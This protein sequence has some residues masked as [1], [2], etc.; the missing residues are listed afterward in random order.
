M[1]EDKKP[2]I[3]CTVCAH[4]KLKE[5][6][7]ALVAPNPNFSAIA[8]IFDLKRDNVRRHLEKGHVAEKITKAA[9]A[10]EALDADDLLKEFQQIQ[11]HQITIFKEAR[12]RKAKGED[13]K[14]K[15]YPDNKL[16]LEALRDQSKT[17]EFKGKITGSFKGE[18]PPGQT[19]VR[20]LSDEEIERR[21]RE[22]FAKRCQ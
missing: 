8:R 10:Q 11:Q 21:A 12:N 20:E 4:P 18:K 3:K 17:V 15:P 19:P 22:I 7:K 16:A 9:A 2:G 1:K 6:N 14:L 5:I 13:G